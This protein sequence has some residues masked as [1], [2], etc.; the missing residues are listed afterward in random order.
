MFEIHEAKPWLARVLG[1]GR[2]KKGGDVFDED[3]LSQFETE[4]KKRSSGQGTQKSRDPKA[5]ELRALVDESLALVQVDR[6][7]AQRNA[8][9]GR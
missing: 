9:M 1:L 7:R 4:M 3:E 6:D 2:K 5:E 8:Q